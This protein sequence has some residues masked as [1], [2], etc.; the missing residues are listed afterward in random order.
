MAGKSGSSLRRGA[1]KQKIATS[2]IALSGRTPGNHK[3]QRDKIA[4]AARQ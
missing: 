1:N 3:D 2:Q 4:S